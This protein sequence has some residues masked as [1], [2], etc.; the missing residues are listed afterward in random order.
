MSNTGETRVRRGPT[1]EYEIDAGEGWR[2]APE[3]FDPPVEIIGGAGERW[4][5]PP[6]AWG[7]QGTVEP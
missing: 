5:V 4:D 3:G 1:G 2:P 7:L 6:G